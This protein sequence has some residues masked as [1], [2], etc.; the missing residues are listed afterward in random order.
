M[1][2]LLRSWRDE[3]EPVPATA[4][5][6][7]L[8][9][10]FREVRAGAAPPPDGES[11]APLGWVLSVPDAQQRTLL[12]AAEAD[13]ELRAL[14]CASEDEANAIAAGLWIGGEPCAVSIQHAGLYASLNSLRGVGIDGRIPLFL[15]IGLRGREPGLDPRDSRSSLVR[16]C[17]P[18]LDTFGVPYARLERAED[19]SRIPEYHRL[20]QTRR[21]PAAVL[22]G[23]E[24]C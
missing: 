6:E 7:A 20:A 8:K 9:Q 10:A 22:V 3:T 17:E 16:Y 2:R 12:A 21:G 19:V 5:V 11:R 4:I 13:P 18:L 14:P 24:T 15:L 1:M 23:R